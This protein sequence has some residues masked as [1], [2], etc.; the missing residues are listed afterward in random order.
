MLDITDV[1]KINYKRVATRHKKYTYIRFQSL[2]FCSTSHPVD[3][4][5]SRANATLVARSI[6]KSLHF[7]LFSLLLLALPQLVPGFGFLARID[8]GSNHIDP[9]HL[10][11][12]TEKP[13]DA[14]KCLPQTIAE[15]T[16]KAQQSNDSNPKCA[17]KQRSWT[18]F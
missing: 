1:G 11:T 17:D 16:A 13:A 3:R 12:L 18:P 9:R 10:S 8:F 4:F 15:D 2:Q 6:Q 7:H 5:H 14:E